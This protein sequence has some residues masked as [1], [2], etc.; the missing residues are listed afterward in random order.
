MER[1]TVSFRRFAASGPLS[2]YW[3]EGPYGD[4]IEATT[5]KG[6]AWLAPNGDLLG[7]EFDDVQWDADD[8][9]LEL[10]NGDVVTVRVRRGK[11]TARAKRRGRHRAA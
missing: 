11:V 10:P 5:G 7:A 8:Q 2:V 9:T 4:A 1:P 3:H 6:V